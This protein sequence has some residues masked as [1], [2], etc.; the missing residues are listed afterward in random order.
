[1]YE[2]ASMIR[3]GKEED[4]EWIAMFRNN[5]KSIL[6]NKG[7]SL[8]EV[9]MKLNISQSKLSEYINGPVRLSDDLIRQIAEAA[10]CTVDE[11]LDETY[12]PWNYG[13]TEEEIT[14]KGKRFK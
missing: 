7:G 4:L 1:M 8:K 2:R 9:S 11:L 6:K 5:L 12:C 3:I 14:K 13:L 10:G